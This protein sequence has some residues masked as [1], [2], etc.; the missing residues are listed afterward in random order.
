MP[1]LAYDGVFDFDEGVNKA[2]LLAHLASR[3]QKVNAGD[4]QISRDSVSFR[5]GFFRGV[6]S[7]NV[8]IPFGRGE[9]IVDDIIHEVHYRLSL[10]QLIFSASAMVG[11]RACSAWFDTDGHNPFTLFAFAGGWVGLVGGNLAIGIPRF[12]RFLREAID[13]LP[14]QIGVSNGPRG[15]SGTRS[16]GS[17]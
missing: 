3:F 12:Q 8:L 16:K 7:W 11:L 14:V 17:D 2:D 6:G 9:L 13:A 15:T 5:G 4:I 1:S 10:R